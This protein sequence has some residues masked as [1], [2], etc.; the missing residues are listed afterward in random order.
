VARVTILSDVPQAT[1]GYGVISFGLGKYLRRKG[2]DVSFIGFQHVGGPVYV[3]LDDGGGQGGLAP[4][5]EGN[6]T[7]SIERAFREADPDLGIHVRDAFALTPKFF[8]QAYSLASLK[9]RPKLVLNTPV[10]CDNLPPEFIAACNSE[11]ELVVSPTEWGREVLLFQGV[12]SRKVEAVPWGYDPESYHPQKVKKEDYGFDPGRPLIGSIGIN[13]QHRKGWPILVKAVGILRRKMD[14]DLY[15]STSPEG[16]FLI[17]HHA[18][19][20]GMK[21][22]I[23]FPQGYSKTW[24]NPPAL[25]NEVYNCLDA[26]ASSS[27]EEGF[28]LPLLEALAVG[29][30]VVCT[31]MPVHREVAGGFGHYAKSSKTY[32]TGWSFGWLADPEDMADQLYRVLDRGAAPGQLDYVKKFAWEKVVERWAEVVNA[33]EELGVKL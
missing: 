22:S 25:A 10:Q 18:A 6:N 14:V 19:A 16:T 30:P 32:P 26:Y 9:G 11:A 5:Y 29:K 13:D 28:N 12:P 4:V 24:G 8:G 3:R 33:H 7:V 1:T 23:I 17:P 31:D 21:G 20:S 27:I 15:L 2:H